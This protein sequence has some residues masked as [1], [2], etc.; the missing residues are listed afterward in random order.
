MAQMGE[1]C[2][3]AFLLTALAATLAPVLAQ[4]DVYTWVDAKGVVNVS[5]LPP[6]DGVRVT[7][8]TQ[9]LPQ[10]IAVRQEA[11]RE[12]A[13]QAEMQAMSDRIRQLEYEV[14]LARRAPPP[15]VEYPP[16]VVM[17]W[18][19][20]QYQI[21]VSPPASSSSG[22]DAGWAGCG[23]WWGSGFYFPPTVAVPRAPNLRRPHASPL[24]ASRP[25]P[26][27]SLPP[28]FNGPSRARG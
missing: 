22:C 27:F 14:E 18:A 21:D 7:N 17:Q 13:R 1:G 16:Q 9:E 10:P 6:P 25:A 15:P 5:N 3:R 23:A 2:F 20:V 11:A 28:L 24:Q 8:V 12:V 4:A 26:V 19:P